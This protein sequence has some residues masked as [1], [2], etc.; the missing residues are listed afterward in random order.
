MTEDSIDYDPNETVEETSPVVDRQEQPAVIFKT[1]TSTDNLTVKE[2]LRNS[3]FNW[4]RVEGTENGDSICAV[5]VKIGVSPLVMV[6]SDLWL[7]YGCL[8]MCP[9]E[10]FRDLIWLHRS[11]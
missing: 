9:R 10:M 8:E 2:N 1:L 11:N 4:V 7:G 6:F 3:P 5:A